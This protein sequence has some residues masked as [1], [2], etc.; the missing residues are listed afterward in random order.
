MIS[1][2]EYLLVTEEFK[3]EEFGDDDKKLGIYKNPTAEEIKL[4]KPY[5]RAIGIVRTGDLFVS[6][7]IEGVVA[8]HDPV[9]IRSKKLYK[10]N[11]FKLHKPWFVSSGKKTFTLQRIRDTDTFA[12][13]ETENVKEIITKH[14][15]I[16]K[17]M[18]KKLRQQNPKLKFVAKSI[19]DFV[20]IR[21]FTVFAK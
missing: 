9:A 21:E 18:F 20:N 4:L 2:S 15:D 7:T 6:A 8:L 12:F 13:G 1:F 10:T 17:Q 14:K 16:V 3:W 11:Y 5:V 19:G